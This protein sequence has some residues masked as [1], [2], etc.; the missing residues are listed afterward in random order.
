MFNPDEFLDPT[1]RSRVRAAR[2]LIAERVRRGDATPSEQLSAAAFDEMPL[3]EDPAAVWAW[4]PSA[5]FRGA[6]R[7]VAFTTLGHYVDI[8]EA[9][10]EQTDQEEDD[11]SCGGEDQRK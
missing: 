8:F 4:M 11:D 6:V 1:F 9:M 7:S 2:S 3:D 5:E 10:A